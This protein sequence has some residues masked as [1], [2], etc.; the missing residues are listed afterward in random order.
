MNSESPYSSEIRDLQQ[1]AQGTPHESLTFSIL[2][3]GQI[4][5]SEMLEAVEHFTQCMHDRGYDT[6]RMDPLND[7]FGEL[8]NPERWSQEEYS[9]ALGSCSIQTNGDVLA[10]LWSSTRKNPNNIDEDEYF[11]SCLKK[12][13]VIDPA[14]TGE[15]YKS[16]F[17]TFIR[18]NADENRHSSADPNLAVIPFLVNEDKAIDTMVR[19]ISEPQKVLYPDHTL[20]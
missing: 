4:S 15:Q 5:D 14:Y 10:S 18:Q 20:N 3:D 8:R 7:N 17:D 9:K 12:L 1:N 16:D 13:E 2:E 6:F 11:I 19:C